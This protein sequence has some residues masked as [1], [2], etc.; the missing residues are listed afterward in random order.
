VT[1][2]NTET[3]AERQRVDFWPLFTWHHDLT[4]T[5]GCNSRAG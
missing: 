5:A 4:A 3:G 2:K 1:E